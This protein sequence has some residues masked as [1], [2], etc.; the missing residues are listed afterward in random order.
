MLSFR[1]L[2]HAIMMVVTNLGDVLRLSAPMIAFAALVPLALWLFGISPDPVVMDFSALDP[3]TDAPSGAAAVEA[4][5]VSVNSPL[6]ILAGIVQSAIGLWVLVAWHRY[7][8]LEERPGR[9]SATVPMDRV[10]GYLGQLILIVLA[11]VAATAV[12]G[13]AVLLVLTLFGDS[14]FGLALSFLL[15]VGCVV[16]VYPFVLRLSVALPAAAIGQRLGLRGAW[17]ATRGQTGLCLGLLLWGVVASLVAWLPMILLAF[18]LP[19][20][21][22]IVANAV[23]QV[24][25]TVVAASV[26]TTLYGYFVQKRVLML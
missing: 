21:L 25:C 19:T 26:L 22:F 10:L 8:L 14:A 12:V 11:S 16:L 4:E 5:I 24:L 7:V 18:V 15:A 1:I 17:E 20:A 6:L 13:L 2:R 9:F 23:F 3:S